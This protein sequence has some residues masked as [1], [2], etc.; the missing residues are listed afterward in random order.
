MS[1]PSI[2]ELAIDGA[3]LIT[4]ARFHDDRGFFQELFHQTKYSHFISGDWP[5]VSFSSSNKN[6]LRGVHCSPYPKM[7]T[8][9]TGSLIDYII[10]LRPLS[11]TYLQHISIQLDEATPKQLLVPAS[12]GHAFVSL[13]DKTLMLYLQGGMWQPE[14]DMEVNWADP[15]LALQL[16]EGLTRDQIIISAKDR[17]A[18]FLSQSRAALEQRQASKEEDVQ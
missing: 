9:L 15:E 4:G 16:P 18:P 10:D 13:Q 7:V 14:R 1:S 17:D 2:S 8:C 12:C 11:P 3:L 5:Q 6:V